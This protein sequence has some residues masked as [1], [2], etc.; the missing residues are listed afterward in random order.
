MILQK[1]PIVHEGFLRK[2]RGPSA[3]GLDVGLFQILHESRP[4]AGA[5]AKNNPPHSSVASSSRI[6]RGQLEL[7]PP[8]KGCPGPVSRPR[9]HLAGCCLTPAG[10]SGQVQPGAPPP[11]PQPAAT[12]LPT[13]P[14]RRSRRPRRAPGCGHTER[15]RCLPAPRRRVFRRLA[16]PAGAPPARGRPGGKG[17]PRKPGTRTRRS[18]PRTVLA[19]PSP[20]PRV[21]RLWPGRPRGRPALPEGRPFLSFI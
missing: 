11:G 10:V 19:Q 21:S 3:S 2:P 13:H 4:R 5:A 14:G 7:R 6:P 12:V 16:R 15:P 18:A 17:A 9:R 1:T 20:A 8:R